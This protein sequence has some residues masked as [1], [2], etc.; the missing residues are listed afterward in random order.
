MA[1]REGPSL[2]AAMLEELARRVRG[3]YGCRVVWDGTSPVPQQVRVVAAGYRRTAVARDVQSAI[4]AAAGMLVPLDRF[5]V[6]PVR[7][8]DELQRPRRFGLA[9]LTVEAG[10]ERT[11]VRVAVEEGRQSFSGRSRGPAGASAVHLAVEATL[12]A[13]RAAVPALGQAT[14]AEV[15]EVT[16]AGQR[17]VLAAVSVAAPGGGERLLLG[18]AFV[19]RHAPEAAA[20]AV[21]DALNRSLE[22]PLPPFASLDD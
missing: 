13:L 19:R 14:P 6:T 16:V 9:A 20:R 4:F 5:V 18:T 7:S 1:A 8:P 15:A 17:V 2:T 21:L 10:P 22:E 3:V 11:E 12:E